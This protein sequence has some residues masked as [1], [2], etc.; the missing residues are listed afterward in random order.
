MTSHVLPITDLIGTLGVGTTSFLLHRLTWP[1][2]D[3]HKKLTTWLHTS[4]ARPS[5]NDG[6]IAVVLDHGEV[7]GW[8][9][10]ERWSEPLGA[11]GSVM[12][13]D[14]LESFVAPEYRMRGIAAFAASGLYAG[15]LHD[16]GLGVAVFRPAMMLVARRAGLYPT[17]FDHVD[18]K[19]VRA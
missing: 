2:S 11:D 7:V 9:R 14:T 10:T 5:E 15:V 18:D 19:W 12:H 16:N 4:S 3:F 13:W 17:L 6:H 8:T 1:G